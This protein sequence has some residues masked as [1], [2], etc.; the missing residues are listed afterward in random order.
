MGKMGE[1]HLEV[2]TS[3]YKRSKSWNVTYIMVTVVNN[4]VMHI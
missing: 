4:I 2:Q 1:G 3:S